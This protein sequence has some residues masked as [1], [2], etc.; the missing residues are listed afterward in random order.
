MRGELC[1]HFIGLPDI[2]LIATGA[3]VIDIG[4]TIDPGGLWTLSIAVA[5]T[6]GRTGRVQGRA[7]A[8]S[9]HLGEV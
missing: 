1:R 9:G 2:H 3:V 4:H 8:S 6:V 7:T 5:G